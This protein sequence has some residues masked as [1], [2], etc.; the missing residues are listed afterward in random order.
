[1]TFNDS[2]R[3]RWISSI[4]FGLVGFALVEMVVWVMMVFV[5]FVA[6]QIAE[7]SS[8]LMI[9]V[10]TEFLVGISY[11]GGWLAR[12]MRASNI[13]VMVRDAGPIER[14]II[15]ARIAQENGDRK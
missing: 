5:I 4:V 7:Q 10:V 11:C 2:V 3:A 9:I 13:D 1:V 15:K 6:V 12:G 8:R 14:D